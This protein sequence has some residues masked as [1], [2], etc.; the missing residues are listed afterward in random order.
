MAQGC[1]NDLHLILSIKWKY[2]HINLKTAVYAS[3]FS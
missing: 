2:T 1:L 3:Q